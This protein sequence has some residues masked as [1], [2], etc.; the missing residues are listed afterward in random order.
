[1][2]TIARPLPVGTPARALTASSS[3]DATVYRGLPGL[4]ANKV[5][6]LL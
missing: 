3:I 2:W 6:I 4:T 5:S 1:M